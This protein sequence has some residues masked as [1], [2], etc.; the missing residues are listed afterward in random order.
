MYSPQDVKDIQAIIIRRL[1][2]FSLPAAALGA[3]VVLSFIRRIEWL[4]I[5]LFVFMC[6][7]ALF[8]WGMAISP[9][10]KYKKYLLSALNGM[11][12]GTEGVFQLW[13]N[14]T[15]EREGVLFIPL[16][17]NI[18]DPAKEED[19]RLFYWDKNLP[20]PDWQKGD[21]LRLVSQDKAVLSWEKL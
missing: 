18:G 20:R 9:L 8:V 4:T 1:A 2:L 21:R 11:N 15:A 19:D 5:L 17:L 13:E 12:R 3:L 16:Y 7:C 10:Q 14:E 6:F